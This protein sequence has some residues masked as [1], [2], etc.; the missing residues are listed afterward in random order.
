MVSAHPP[1]S[2]SSSHLTKVSETVPKAPFMISIT[3]TF[4]FYK[5]LVFWQGP[6]TCIF[7]R[8]LWFSRCGLSGRQSPQFT[9]FP[10][11]CQQSLGLVFWLRL[12]I[13]LY[14]KILMNFVSLIFLDG[15][16]FEHMPL[17]KFLFLAQFPVDHLP[18]SVVPSVVLFGASLLHSL[19][20][21]LI[22]SSLSPDNLHLLFC[23]IL[24]WLF[25]FFLIINIVL[26]S[27]FIAILTSS[28]RPFNINLTS[29]IP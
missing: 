7:F 10:F 1:I 27:V 25:V 5:F 8:F 19:I 4:M 3:I 21:R 29:I 6:K 13:Y 23:C 11:L 22:V 9:R 28:Y 26:K 12:G 20:M 24:L 18:H 17:V 16:Q 14:L 2:D 15:F